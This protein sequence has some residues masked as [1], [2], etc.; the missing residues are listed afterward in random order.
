LK[1]IES[2]SERDRLLVEDVVGVGPRKYPSGGSLERLVYMDSD[3]VVSPCTSYTGPNS[4]MQLVPR[5]VREEPV[6][7]EG[8]PEVGREDITVELEMQQERLALCRIK[9]FCSSILKK[10]APPLLREV[11][12]SSR[13]RAEAQPF[14]PRRL[15]RSAA[16][17]VLE[18]EKKA[19]KASAAETV[20]LKALGICPEELFVDE[21][22]LASFNE[23]FD[24]PLGE[25]HVRVMAFISGKLVPQSFEQ[26]ES[27]RLVV[28]VH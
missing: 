12:S 26:Q 28:E 15:T 21:E 1:L 7:E 3:L 17:T 18:K 2:V 14:T 23:I 19:S 5:R 13:L 6:L 16:M 11:E 4:D 22:H 25:R 24:S 27:C 9:T 20:L 8:V 10:L